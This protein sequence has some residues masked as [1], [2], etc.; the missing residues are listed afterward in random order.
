MSSVRV[1][2]DHPSRR[3]AWPIIV[4]GVLDF[5]AVALIL[6]HY[7]TAAG[8]IAALVLAALILKGVRS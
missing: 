4:A 6:A 2:A 7:G 8:L 5:I 1:Q 3:R